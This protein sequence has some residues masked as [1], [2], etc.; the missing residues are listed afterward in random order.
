MTVKE[1]EIKKNND[2][3]SW[4]IFLATLGAVII[5]VLTI[6]FPAFVIRTFGGFTDYTGINPFEIG[7]WAIPFFITNF[8][9]FGIVILYFKNRL[10][11]LIRKSIQFIFKFEVSPRITLLVIVIIIGFYI[12]LTASELSTEEKW[13]DYI[14]FKPS[15]EKWTIDEVTKGDGIQHVRYFLLDLSMKVFNNYKIIPFITSITLLVL[16][17]FITKEITHKRFAGIVSMVILLQS[18]TFLTYDTSVVYSNFWVLFYLLSLYTISKSW[19]VSPISFIL[20]LSSKPLTAI[21]VP[22]S[23][24]FIYASSISRKKKILLTIT[25]GT[26]IIIGLAF[27]DAVPGQ[28]SFNSHDF[29]KAFNSIS[30]QLRLD[31][32]V[33]FSL[34][35]LTVGL[36]IASRKNIFHANS[37]MILILGML[38]VQPIMAGLTTPSSEPYRFMPLIVFFAISVGILFSKRFNS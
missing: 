32:M 5:T 34:L 22:M 35:P 27:F 7:I 36:F 3:L 37:M 23:F 10:P 18:G 12:S 38:L 26:I 1:S 24:F 16:T 30:Y 8:V 11:K 29:W 14:R 6:V 21:F 31:G 25:Y 15:L 33:L 2:F 17:Y 19:P 9:I 13:V 28:E 20:S 4:A